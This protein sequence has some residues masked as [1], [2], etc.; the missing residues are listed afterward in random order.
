NFLNNP[1]MPKK[2]IFFAIFMV[3]IAIGVFLPL[4]NT[5][6]AEADDAVSVSSD[7]GEPAISPDYKT[8]PGLTG[9][10]KQTAKENWDK[11]IGCIMNP[12]ACAFRT[13]MENL[14]GILY[15]VVFVMA[16]LFDLAGYLVNY[17]VN[18]N[19]L[20]L[21]HPI[22]KIGWMVTRDL[23]NLGFV[24]AIIIIAFTTIVRAAG[25]ETKKML[26]HLIAAAILINF[27]FVIAGVFT[28]FAGM[29]GGYFLERANIGSGK[30]TDL[31]GAF[32][33]SF[34]IQRWSSTEPAKKSE[35][36][37]L[38]NCP[39]PGFGGLSDDFLKNCPKITKN[40]PPSP[41]DTYTAI[42]DDA[43][44]M[45]KLIVSIIFA[46]IF[47]LLGVIS[48][49][50]IAVALLVRYIALGMLLILMPIAWLFW[51]LPQT[52]GLW[53]QWWTKFMQ[54]VFFF[55]AV[56]FFLYLAVAVTF[57]QGTTENIIPS[58]AGASE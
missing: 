13:V 46:I 39:D 32:A 20:V 52:E 25:F 42:K 16:R 28:D 51:I 27:S 12:G 17:A 58:G 55:P 1:T 18:L 31:A 47:T 34:Q 44:K 37:E 41:P 40:V 26:V 11:S 45:L 3:A 36:R 19:S 33:N 53:K 2:T 7:E 4:D 57:F 14:S 10:L 29:L 50:G 21:I 35:K 49:L 23:A 15:A 24:L 30:N 54:Q 5:N 9:Y 6:T 38:Y 8:A 22:V 56:S 43:S 48:F